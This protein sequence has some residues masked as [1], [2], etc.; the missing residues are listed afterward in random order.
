[1]AKKCLKL[2]SQPI[3]LNPQKHLDSNNYKL[4]NKKP[5]YRIPSDRQTR[6]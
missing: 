3:K 1:M 2:K 5:T 6:H 4:V